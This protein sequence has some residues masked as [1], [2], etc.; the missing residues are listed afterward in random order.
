[1][2]PISNGARNMTLILGALFFFV[3]ASVAHAQGFVPLAPIPDLT[4]G[5]TTD[6]SG[7]ANF[8]NNL[9]K[10]AIGLAAAL[11]VIQIVWAGLDIAIWHK[12]A[13]STITNNK[14]KIYNALFGLVLVLSP[15]L[16][17]SIIN[18]SILNL[19]LNLPALQTTT[20]NTTGLSAPS[21]AP[22]PALA[23]ALT[24]KCTMST[25][26][27]SGIQAVICPKQE[28]AQ[29]FADSCNQ[30]GGTGQSS[31][32]PLSSPVSYRATCDKPFST[33]TCSVSGT[34]GIL[35][36]ANCP[37]SESATTW[38]QQNCTNGKLS[39]AK[40]ENKSNGVFTNV[41]I[42]A[43]NQSF[44]FIDKKGILTF[45]INALQP[46]FSTATRPNNGS[47]AMNFASICRNANIGF[48]TCV[49]D[50]PGLTSSIPCQLT[51]TNAATT[52]KCYS[53]NL[54]CEDVFTSGKCSTNPSWTPFQ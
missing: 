48:Q 7:L 31:E 40:V 25:S 9:Y 6:P 15:V 42:C 28:D 24:A 20:T 14:E 38:G 49:S 53:E 52:W 45:T 44:T 46:L 47:E 3:I 18:P 12:D 30:K 26:P 41:A 10:Y 39:T 5:A 36:I 27:Y 33:G 37:T 4:Q 51:G 43:G 29:A 35:Q 21:T 23:A 17:F 1:M 8:L 11:A 13:V 19:S 2:N 34:S 22:D 32:V 16:V 50:L 54:T